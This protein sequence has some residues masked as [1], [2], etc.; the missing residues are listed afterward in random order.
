MGMWLNRLY[1]FGALL[2]A[3]TLAATLA[4]V[5][6]AELEG[7]GSGLVQLRSMMALA[8]SPTG[9]VERAPVT[10]LLQ[11]RSPAT[12]HDLCRMSPRIVD[13][14]VR[15]L[16]V[17]PIPMG[18]NRTIDPSDIEPLLTEAANK[19]LGRHQVASVSVVDGARSLGRGVASRL[20]FSSVLGC[21]DVSKVSAG[22]G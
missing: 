6:E 4:P 2:V 1:V 7:E 22:G 20:P 12:S 11:A 3:I 10:L 14:L 15:V 13:A 21:S 16:A 5:A 19:A 18:R 9:A 17:N 8:V